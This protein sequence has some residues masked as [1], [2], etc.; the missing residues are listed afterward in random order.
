[1]RGSETRPDQAKIIHV[2]HKRLAIAPDAGQ[3]LSLAFTDMAMDANGIFARQIAATAQ[4]GIRT[5][6]RDGGRDRSA[7][8]ALARRPSK[9][10]M[11]SA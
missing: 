2:L 9:L 5:M 7:V 8:T 4:E 6:M 1:M 10:P 3:G 11:F